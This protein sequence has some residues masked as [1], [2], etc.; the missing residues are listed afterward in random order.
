MQNHE[1]IRLFR[2]VFFSFILCLISYT[3]KPVWK[4]I[5]AFYSSS[6]NLKQNIFAFHGFNLTEFI[7][8]SEKAENR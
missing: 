4:I 7:F 8:S 1:S 2:F 5:F 3:I 6:L